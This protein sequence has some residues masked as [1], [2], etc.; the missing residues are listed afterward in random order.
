MPILA[1]LRGGLGWLWEFFST[2][3]GQLV[4]VGLVCWFWSA[5]RV[6]LKWE[7]QIE[8]DRQTAL[9]AAKAEQDRQA[10]AAREIAEAA[11]DRLAEEQALVRDLREQIE[12]FDKE[13]TAADEKPLPRKPSC[14]PAVVRPCRVDDAFARRVQQL[15]ATAHRHAPVPSRRAH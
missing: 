14:S 6:N 1:F 3:I 4:L 13:E 7:A 10:A 12:A 11:T 5:H 9:A 15:D 2:H 8:S